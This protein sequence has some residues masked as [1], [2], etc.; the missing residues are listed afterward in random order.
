M[1]WPTVRGLAWC[2][3]V[4]S[5]LQH[6]VSDSLAYAL[7]LTALAH[8]GAQV[9]LRR[10]A[11]GD[12]QM[13]ASLKMK[14]PPASA[15]DALEDVSVYE[16]LSTSETRSE[17]IDRVWFQ[18]RWDGGEREAMDSHARRVAEEAGLVPMGP[19]GAEGPWAVHASPRQSR[20]K[21]QRVGC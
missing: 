6:T 20:R 8:Q 2:T 19:L 5:D 21:G 9:H 10:Y 11:R 3:V 16:I 17:E 1:T 13:R 15:L 4:N 7:H 14:P 12:R 18:R